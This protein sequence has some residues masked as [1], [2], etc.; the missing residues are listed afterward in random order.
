MSYLELIHANHAAASAAIMLRAAPLQ[1]VTGCGRF[2]GEGKDLISV[3]VWHAGIPRT[4]KCNIP[5]MHHAPCMAASQGQL[6]TIKAA[7]QSGTAPQMR[8]NMLQTLMRGVLPRSRQTQGSL[9]VRCGYQ[10]AA[11]PDGSLRLLVLLEFAPPVGK[12]N[13]SPTRCDGLQ[14]PSHETH[15]RPA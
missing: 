1:P 13:A 7:V 10:Q 15:Q 14:L 9:C 4:A 11:T 2:G 12:A 6:D 5:C 3:I 8:V